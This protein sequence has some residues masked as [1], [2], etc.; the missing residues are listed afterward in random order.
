MHDDELGVIGDGLTGFIGF[1]LQLAM[2]VI[3][4]VTILAGLG[5]WWR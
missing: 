1:L 3:F 4:A 2:A 5:W